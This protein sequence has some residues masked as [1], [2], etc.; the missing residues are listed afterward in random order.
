M[1]TALKSAI[2]AATILAPAA[3]LAVP[4]KFDTTVT[5]TDVADMRNFYGPAVTNALT[6]DFLNVA[7]D[8][9]VT[10]DARVSARVDAANTHFATVND[11]GKTGADRRGFVPDYY[12]AN[13][14]TEPNDDLGILY[15][16]LAL[17]YAGLDLTI[18]F[19]DG[20]GAAS[21]AFASEYSVDELDLLIY[22]VDGETQGWN[23]AGST[24]SEFFRAFRSDGLASYRLGI[25]PQALTATD[26]GDSILFSDPGTNFSET[27]SSGGAVLTFRDTSS[28]TLAFGSVSSAGAAVNRVFSAIDGNL[29]LFDPGTYQA[30]VSLSPSAVPL[31]AAAPLL[32]AGLAG[33]GALA[34]RRRRRRP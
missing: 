25:S 26:E 12:A 11:D 34:R 6:V 10:I 2:A 3:S 30:P 5:A 15:E 20:T 24:Q 13:G 17:G 28:L 29:S 9:G 7:T 1:R 8:R 21:G 23:G 33:L 27:D 18:T 31:P 16:T 4:L 14:A 32:A 19:Y 22:D